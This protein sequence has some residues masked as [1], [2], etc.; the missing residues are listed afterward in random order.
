MLLLSTPKAPGGMTFAT[1]Q[2]GSFT[3]VLDA[4]WE[5]TR[6]AW[7]ANAR[8]RALEDAYDNR[9][10]AVSEATGQ[11]LD[12]PLRAIP[13]A[14]DYRE[15]A[16]RTKAS[17]KALYLPDYMDEKFQRQ[18]ARIAEGAP[19]KLG[20]LRPHVPTVQ[21]AVDLA[22]GAERK[23]SDVLSRTSGLTGTLANLAGGVGASFEDPATYVLAPIGLTGSASK[24]LLWNALRAAATNA[25]AQATMEPFIQQWR[26]E[27]GLEAGLV[28]A[29]KDIGFAGA[30][31]GGLDVLFRGTVRGF[32]AARGTG[33]PAPAPIERGATIE[34]AIPRLPDDNPIK[35]AAAGDDAALVTAAQKIETHLTPSQRGALRALEDE[36]GLK[37]DTG[38]DLAAIAQ[39][40][41]HAE[42]PATSPPPPPRDVRPA[43]RTPRLDDEAPAPA[44]IGETFEADGKPVTFKT[45]NPA[46]VSA[47][48]STFQFKGGGD[49]AGVTERLRGVK[50][51]DPLAAG[52]AV[53]FERLDGTLVIADG[54]QRLGLAK[55]LAAD[56]QDARLTAFVMREAD[57]W[58][59]EDV[60]ALA[61]KKNMQEGT[62]SALDAAKVIRERPDLV[63]DSLPVTEGKLRQARQLAR[64][65]PE[66]F[67][68]VAAGVV[69]EPW[70]ALVGES[71]SDPALHKGMIEELARADIDT[72]DQ[73]RLMIADMLQLPTTV[74]QQMTLFG[75]MTTMRPLVAERAKVL[76]GALT[77][78]ARDAKVFA[79]LEREAGIVEAAGNVLARDKNAERATKAA[80][81]KSLIEELALKRGRVS[82]M[83]S[84]AAVAVSSGTVPAKRAA[85]AFA[86][87]V[88]AILDAEGLKGLTDDAPSP[89]PRGLD[90][91]AG[92]EAKAQVEARMAE[93]KSVLGKGLAQ[94]SQEIKGGQA[95]VDRV[96]GRGGKAK[97]SLS[98]LDM[99][100]EARKARA[101][102]QG[103]DTSVVF[104]RGDDRARDSVRTSP[105]YG[106]VYTSMDPE[107]ANG[108]VLATKQLLD[109]KTPVPEGSVVIP[110]W[111]KTA[112]LYD[113]RNPEHRA[114]L[115][116]ALT[117][118]I[119]PRAPSAVALTADDLKRRIESGYYGTLEKPAVREVLKELGFTGYHAQEYLGQH[120]SS[121]AFFNPTDLRSTS[122]AFEPSSQGRNGLLFALSPA[123]AAAMPDVRVKLNEIAATLPKAVRIR[124]YDRLTFNDL[125]TH[126]QR[127]APPGVEAKSIQGIWDPEQMVIHLA[128]STADPVATLRHEQVHMM[129]ALGLLSDDDYRRLVRHAEKTGARKAYKI[130]ATYGAA[131]KAQHADKAAAEAVLV[132]ETV[133][134]LV[135][136]RL[137]GKTIGGGLD[138]VLK[139]VRDFLARLRDALGLKG[140]RTV[141]DVFATIERGGDFAI[142]PPLDTT[143]RFMFGGERAVTADQEA[144]AVAKQ[145]QMDGK[146]R[147]DIWRK[148]GWLQGV[149][150]RWRFEIDDSSARLKG[151]QKRYVGSAL[152]HSEVFDAYPDLRKV[153]VARVQQSGGAY[154]KSIDTIELG[155]FA[156]KP[157]LLHEMQ[158]AIQSG[159]RES[160]A[161]GGAPHHF[162]K[163]AVAREKARLDAQ[164][165]AW[166]AAGGESTDVSFSEAEVRW[167]LYRRLAGEVEARTV[168]K[169]AKLT[170]AER[171]AQPPWL[172]YDVPEDQQFVSVSDSVMFS[173][174]PDD[175]ETALG[176]RLGEAE[177][178]GKV[179]AAARKLAGNVEMQASWIEGMGLEA[180][181]A[182]EIV[183]LY[184]GFLKDFSALMDE[185]TA[186]RLARDHVAD[187]LE[188]EALQRK[189]V[190][191]LQLEATTRAREV[192]STHKNARGEVDPAQAMIGML[193]HY[194][195]EGTPITSSVEG[196]RKAILGRAH[197]QMEEVL[198][199]FRK[200]G[201]SGRRMNRAQMPN[202]VRELFGEGTGDAA[203][204]AFAKA[205]TD[206]ADGLRQR[207][208]QA[209]GAVGKLEKWGLPQVHDGQALRKRGLGAWKAD[210][211][212]L[213]DPAKMRHPL[214]GAP[215]TAAQVSDSLD[216]VYKRIVTDGMVDAGETA[217]G[218][219]ALH[220]QHAEHRFLV[221]KDA[222]AW[223]KYQKAYGS[224]GPEGVFAAMMN[225]VNLMSRDIAAMEVLGPN[226]S[227]TLEA[228]I[229]FVRKEGSNAAG[230]QPALFPTKSPK[231]LPWDPAAYMGG[232]I[233]RARDM[234]SHMHGEANVPVNGF[235][236]NTLAA[237]RNITFG[238][239]L[240]SATLSSLSDLGRQQ[241]HRRFAGVFK[242]AHTG[243]DLRAGFSPVA[244]VGDVVQQFKSLNRRE[245]VRS[246]LIL[247]S[248]LHVLHTNA[249]YAGSF[250]GP[251]WSQVFADRLLTWGLLT[252]WTQANRH[253][254][255]L[256]IMAE[257]A[258][259]VGKAFDALDPAL[260]RLFGRYGMGAA[261]WDALR[262]FEASIMGD[263]ET[264]LRGRE[265]ASGLNPK[266]RRRGQPGRALAG[267][268]AAPDLDPIRY[269]KPSDIKD[270]RLAERYLEMILQETERAVPSG[271]VA[272]KA[273]W[274]G[275]N[276]PGTFKGELLR[277]IS[278]LKSYGTIVLMQDW[279]R[280][281]SEIASGRPL[282]GAR[283][284]A[285][286]AI[287][288]TLLGALA[289][290][291]K[292]L[293][294]GEDPR[295]MDEPEFW[296][297]AMLQGGGLGIYGDYLFGSVNRFGGGFA[298]S[299][300]GPVTSRA[301]NLWNLTGGNLIQLAQDEPTN[302]GREAVGFARMNLSLPFYARLAYERVLLDE[303]QKAV[304]PEARKA[305]R[306]KASKLKTQFKTGY[307]W[308]PGETGP[309]RAPSFA[310]ALGK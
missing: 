125:P 20:V 129:R 6:Y 272:N 90:E 122:A 294:R 85:E 139:P 260:Q 137:T 36:T 111:A 150:G 4:S 302:F 151:G 178:R 198:W 49:V 78:L 100:P 10:K 19:D 17:G 15:I 148:T 11:T 192:L 168:E 26:A 31:G 243:R 117:P 70:G 279:G 305:F 92:V 71:V 280:F 245:A 69:P 185:S 67:D 144:L 105:D 50:R 140:L 214:T 72:S 158:H 300:A 66:A 152:D 115:E 16:R 18:L 75:E 252:P 86:R 133:A 201:G 207:F 103:F 222:D 299:L 242:T 146:P 263:A 109:E 40:I 211:S 89:P 183:K 215:M 46:D 229:G 250:N 182:E 175:A 247:E 47:D 165:S 81:L 188:T 113:Y 262:Q 134:H 285:A 258:D 93:V 256:S 30:V 293:S 48:A 162:G 228:M 283:F 180:G 179:G 288:S 226:P 13:T 154:M 28:P 153:A 22:Q 220:K 268:D 209:G 25:G 303:L 119:D 200:T 114:R 108:A 221:F 123:A 110:M 253:V 97:F 304:D 248:A 254:F 194:G 224:G 277:T 231:G 80:A 54:H 73:A 116:K 57:G 161:P 203:A 142:A 261:E 216:I 187:L 189:R 145:M 249:R 225:H 244:I 9:I 155:P 84:E 43:A 138:K 1:G 24:S 118:L 88:G 236:A 131:I 286:I 91:P 41:R 33:A 130:D 14:D 21:D 282:R 276:Q 77:T 163:E 173:L 217:G 98:G 23:L 76:S 306:R 238:S 32:K 234:W 233:R 239:S 196:R 44:R 199:N 251:M 143:P 295:P 127:T 101:E 290:Q 126:I 181:D 8:W 255:G 124:L 210:I 174:A 95:A 275:A 160:F 205:W 218:R 308:A 264:F 55:R 273:F 74:E 61:A 51:W 107:V 164:L 104:Y 235:L 241:V 269:L 208:N 310:N 195:L 167:E 172:D 257:V 274:I 298:G 212:P 297:A 59:P 171:R 94:I 191:L 307:W 190:A 176:V 266:D 169:R 106:A 184:H 291:L 3:E 177:L 141:E 121:T 281:A 147:E 65:E 83:L 112:G 60:R 156:G 237:V 309:R 128:L 2:D 202:V 301:S 68:M 37:I 265:P 35:Q 193:E 219:G 159:N 271:T 197:A 204:K 230:G 132:E 284:M 5:S 45:L 270:G 135:A 34:E 96:A 296:G 267:K 12:N 79:T 82:D 227:L 136:D 246:G 240:G 157:I 58:T 99:S 287:S 42:D 232:A 149:D 53:V 63:D 120:A 259:N 62:G 289:M 206:T 102:A 38:E 39:A 213:L 27:A 292:S 170:A 186:K 87:R 64:L 56:G 52:K 29:L 278:M 7:N 223:L 166:R